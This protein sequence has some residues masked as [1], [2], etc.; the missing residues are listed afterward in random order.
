[1]ESK[2]GKVTH[3]F[4]KIMV[5]ALALQAEIKVGDTLRFTS[6]STEL[7]QTITSMQINKEAVESA[8]P[9]EDVAIKVK[10]PVRVGDLVYKV[11]E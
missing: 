6:G 1:M 11:T 8:K 2:V 5:C 3:Y 7:T 10:E 9:G 4:G